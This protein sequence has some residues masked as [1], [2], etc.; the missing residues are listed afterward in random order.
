[1]ASSLASSEGS[2]HV[3]RRLTSHLLCGGESYAGTPACHYDRPH[4]K[5]LNT[6]TSGL[7]AM[8]KAVGSVLAG[9]NYFFRPA[10]LIVAG[11]AYVQSSNLLSISNASESREN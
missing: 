10:V 1:M 9:V 7:C 5:S 8:I 2:G 6:P 3:R 4:T 11:Q